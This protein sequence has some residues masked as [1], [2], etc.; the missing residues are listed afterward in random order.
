M[1]TQYYQISWLVMLAVLLLAAWWV[2][3]DGGDDE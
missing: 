2:S 3:R 1:T